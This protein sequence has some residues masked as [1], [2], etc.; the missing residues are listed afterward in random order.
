MTF[1]LID[2]DTE[3]TDFTGSES[4]ESNEY[5]ECTVSSQAL[6]RFGKVW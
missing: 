2:L 5:T 1:V 4:P 3:S 6:L